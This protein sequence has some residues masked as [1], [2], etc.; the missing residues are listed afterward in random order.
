MADGGGNGSFESGGSGS[1]LSQLNLSTGASART[2][3][4]PAYQFDSPRGLVLAGLDLFVLS[5]GGFGAPGVVTVVDASSGA[6]GEGAQ[7]RKGQLRRTCCHGPRRSGPVR[8]GRTGPG[9]GGALVEFDTSSG[10]LVRVIR[11]AR[12]DMF[13]PLAMVASG[14]D[15]FVAGTGSLLG[16]DGALTEVNAATG[17]LVRVITGKAYDF[18][19]PTGM[20]TNGPDLFVAD[21]SIGAGPIEA[22]SVTEVNAATGALVRVLAGARFRF[23]YS[24]DMVVDGPDLFVGNLGLPDRDDAGITEVNTTTGAVLKVLTGPDFPHP[25]AMAADGTHLLIAQQLE[26]LCSRNQNL[27]SNYGVAAIAG[28]EVPVMLRIMP[29]RW[30]DRRI[31]V[32][33]GDLGTAFSPRE[34]AWLGQ[35][36]V[37]VAIY[38][39]PAFRSRWPRPGRNSTN[40]SNVV[41]SWPNDG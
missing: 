41:A 7:P 12:Y 35:V 36:E 3:S 14:P 32:N 18:G 15:L 25:I 37:G 6:L 2:I 13:G 10:A 33:R 38:R 23:N 31:F 19:S 20:A 16:G 21:R 28:H 24:Y 26:R 5:V 34:V 29:T 17:A 11:G 8:I 22:N 4:G 1:A 30:Q 9:G 39:R 40:V 27:G